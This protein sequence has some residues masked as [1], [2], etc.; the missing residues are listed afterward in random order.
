MSSARHGVVR[1]EDGDL[2][3][4]IADR[5][6]DLQCSQH[7][8]ARC[9]QDEVEWHVFV[10]HLDGAKNLFRVVDVDVARNRKAEE[11]HGLLPVHE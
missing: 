1:D 4:V 3:L 2:G 6:R 11:P 7:Q 5:L 10:G 8:P 9:V